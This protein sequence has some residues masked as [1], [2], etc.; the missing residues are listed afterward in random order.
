MLFKKLIRDLKG[1][2]SQFIT[3]FLMVFLGVF[4]F[5]GIHSYMDGMKVFGD[6]YYADNNLPDLW[7]YGE[8]FSSKDLK[9]IKN[10]DIFI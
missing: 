10:I 6:K 8:N 5:A 1:N 2:L 7:V 9:D 3:V 4:V